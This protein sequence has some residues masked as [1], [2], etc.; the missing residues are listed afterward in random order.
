MKV[1]NSQIFAQQK[2]RTIDIIADDE[3]KKRRQ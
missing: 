1:I 3:K 2:N